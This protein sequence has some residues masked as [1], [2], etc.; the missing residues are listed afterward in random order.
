MQVAFLVRE[1]WRGMS[2]RAAASGELPPPKGL[3]R[4]T[5]GLVLTRWDDGR[6]ADVDNLVLL[7]AA[8]AEAHEQ[9]STFVAQQERTVVS[10]LSRA[11][12]C[13]VRVAGLR[14]VC[15]CRICGRGA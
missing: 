10:S 1:V 15:D 4:D 13:Q 7:T 3:S 11:S 2:A 6:P 12:Y 14:C 5:L 8:E 9:A